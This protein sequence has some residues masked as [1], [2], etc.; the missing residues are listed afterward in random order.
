MDTSLSHQLI[1]SAF[2]VHNTLGT[3]FLESVYQT[4]LVHELGLSGLKAEAECKIDVFYK[5]AKV[6]LYYTDI[7]VEGH[8]ILEIKC[9]S[10]I[11]NEHIFQVKNYL[12]G[13]GL[14]DAL[15][16]NF[17]PRVLEFMRVFPR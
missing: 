1:S 3:G 12:R 11:I 15:I 9:C 8:F 13:T 5:D 7:L 17:R 6:G 14:K 10:K 2:E 16:F 4:A